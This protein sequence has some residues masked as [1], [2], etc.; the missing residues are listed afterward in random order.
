MKKTWKKPELKRMV[1][2]AA[3]SGPRNNV[4]DISSNGNA[5]RS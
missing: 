5:S 3:E 2:G 4:N 1:A